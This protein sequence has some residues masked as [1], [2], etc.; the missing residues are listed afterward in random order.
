MLIITK[1]FFNLYTS[2]IIKLIFIIYQKPIDIFSKKLSTINI[3]SFLYNKT[4]L[5]KILSSISNLSFIKR[6]IS[7]RSNF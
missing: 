4:T 3:I 7:L 2:L 6:L 5:A 1:V